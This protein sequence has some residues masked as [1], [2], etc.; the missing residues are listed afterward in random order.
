MLFLENIR[1][2][3]S[4]IEQK[5][6]E[7]T[8][9]V[10]YRCYNYKTIHVETLHFLHRED[11]TRYPDERQRVQQAFLMIVHAYS[12]VRRDSTT[13]SSKASEETAE[14]RHEANELAKLRYRDF[15]LVHT[16]DEEGHTRFGVRPLFSR[17]K[18]ENRRA[19]RLLCPPTDIWIDG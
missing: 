15:T 6:N 13:N 11:S 10:F 18:A 4:K 16:A 3:K 9:I 19:Q 1:N 14:T 12:S 8:I 17:S 5:K 2:E 7:R